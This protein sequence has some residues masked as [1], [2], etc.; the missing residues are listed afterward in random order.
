MITKKE[1]ELLL[2]LSNGHSTKDISMVF[3]EPFTAIEHHRRRINR[4]L[5]A[6]NTPQA[7][8]IAFRLNLIS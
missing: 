7:I 3:Y 5:G 8:A 1:K 2:A 4:K 6:R